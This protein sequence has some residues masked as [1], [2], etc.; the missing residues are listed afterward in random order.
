MTKA[1]KVVLL[2]VF[3]IAACFFPVQ[4]PAVEQGNTLQ[5]SW[6]KNTY[7]SAEI[8]PTA[9]NN[10]QASPLFIP[11]M[12]FM[13]L[14]FMLV[15]PPLARLKSHIHSFIPTVRRLYILNPVKF[16]SKFM[17]QVPVHL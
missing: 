10:G 4:H 13:M 2:A 8:E 12:I 9:I 6:V 14:I 15:P 5:L 16:K 17:A 7:P 11:L 1:A 3:L